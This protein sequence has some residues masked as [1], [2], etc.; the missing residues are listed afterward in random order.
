[1]TVHA[2]QPRRLQDG[3]WG[4]R[5]SKVTLDLDGYLNCLIRDRSFGRGGGGGY[6]N[7]G[8]GNEVLP[9]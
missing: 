2:I 7:L 8:G 9:V 6:K 3:V 4:S 5:L 1:M